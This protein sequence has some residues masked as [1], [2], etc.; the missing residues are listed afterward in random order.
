MRQNKKQG[1]QK[2][3]KGHDK[4]QVEDSEEVF[5]KILKQKGFTL[6]NPDIQTGWEAFKEMSSLTFKCSDNGLLFETGMY[7]FSGENLYYV[8]FVRQFTMVVDEEY[9]YMEQLHLDFYCQPDEKFASFKERIWTYDFD[10]DFEKF[11]QAVEENSVFQLL[12][13]SQ[14]TKKAEIYLEEV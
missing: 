3:Q 1:M 10:D 13:K 2:N 8:S 4:L 12:K 14:M 11:L 9:D 5:K 7:D 6:K